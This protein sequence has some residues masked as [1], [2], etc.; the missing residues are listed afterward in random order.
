MEESRETQYGTRWE[1]FSLVS[2]APIFVLFPDLER[3]E[4]RIVIAV[5]KQR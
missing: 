5:W 3:V 2:M 4:R 1:S